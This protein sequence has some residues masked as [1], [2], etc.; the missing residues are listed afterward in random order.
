M[1]T[2]LWQFAIVTAASVVVI[3]LWVLFV[4]LARRTGEDTPQEPREEDRSH[5]HEGGPRE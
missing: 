5:D 4:Y 2:E 1:G 3:V